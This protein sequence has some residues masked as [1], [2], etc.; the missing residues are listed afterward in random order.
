MVKFER[1]DKVVFEKDGKEISGVIHAVGNYLAGVEAGVAYHAVEV[2]KLSHA[3]PARIAGFK[4]GDKARVTVDAVGFKA[5]TIITLFRD[6]G[7]SNPLW[8]GPNEQYRNIYDDVR[9]R[10]EG[11]FLSL[12][13]VDKL[14]AGPKDGVLWTDAPEGATHYSLSTDHAEKW[15]KLED[16]EWYYHIRY[17]DK[18]QHYYDEE[19]AYVETQVAIPVVAAV[20]PVVEAPVKWEKG[21]VIESVTDVTHDISKGHYYILTEDVTSNEQV[22]FLDDGQYPRHRVARNYKLVLKRNK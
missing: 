9:G 13:L 12:Y 5:G 20:E 21:D 16:G 7:S 19:Y 14:T 2:E 1:G 10:L 15:H 6:D 3:T 17:C 22:K 4:E 8:E 18:W 11:A